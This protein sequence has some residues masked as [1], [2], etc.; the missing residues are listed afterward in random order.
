MTIQLPSS[1]VLKM[2]DIKKNM[3]ITSTAPLSLGNPLFRALAKKKTGTIK[4]SDFYSANELESLIKAG[5]D[6]NGNACGYYR[7][8]WGENDRPQF[9]TQALVGA[10]DAY[11]SNPDKFVFA[12]DGNQPR[13]TFRAL[14]MNNVIY[15]EA[16]AS[17]YQY[18]A[19]SDTT[20]WEW[21]GFPAGLVTG[22]V[23]ELSYLLGPDTVSQPP[24]P[25]GTFPVGQGTNW[26]LSFED[27]FDL[28]SLDNTKWTPH[29]WYNG[30]GQ[31]LNPVGVTNYDISGS[32]LRIWPVQSGGTWIPRDISTHGKFSQVDGYWEMKGRASDNKGIRLNFWMLNHDTDARPMISGFQTVVGHVAG[33]WTASGSND[34]I[35]YA[36]GVTPTTDGQWALYSRYKDLLPVKPAINLTSGD[37]VFGIKK[38]SSRLTFHLDGAEMAGVDLLGPSTMTLPMYIILSVDYV[39]GDAP[40]AD[41]TTVQNASGAFLIDY[42]RA[43]TP[44]TGT[45][46]GE[47]PT[48]LPSGYVAPVGQNSAD[49]PY[50]TF[51][52]EFNQ[53]SAEPDAAKWNKQLWYEANNGKNN[54]RVQDGN[55]YMWPELP[56]ASGTTDHNATLDT[57]GK[58][59]QKYGYF[60]VRAKMPRG[61]GCWPAFWL[62]NHDLTGV[63]PEVD[64]YEMYSGGNTGGNDWGDSSMIPIKYAATVHPEIEGNAALGTRISSQFFGYKNFSDEWH[65]FGFKWI[66]GVTNTELSFYLD[67]SPMGTPIV[68]ANANFDMRMYLILDLWLGGASGQAN[69][70]ETPTGISNSMIVDYVRAWACADGSTVVEGTMP[71]LPESQGGKGGGST[72]PVQK[73]I[74]AFVGNST[75]WGYKS[76]VGGQVSIPYPN[77]FGQRK[78]AYETRNHGVNSTTTAHW[79]AG[80][81]GL[82]Q[83]FAAF[84]AANSNFK[85]VCL[86]FGT[87]DQFDMTTAQFKTNLKAMITE[88]RKVNTRIPILITPFAADF[89]GLAAYAQ[90]VRE[91][92]A[93]VQVAVIDKYTWSLG[94]IQNNGGNVRTFIP[95]GVHPSD[96][97]YIDGGAY[98]ANQWDTAINYVPPPATSTP[99]V[100]NT[101]LFHNDS[102][103]YKEIP[104]GAALHSNNA[105]L[106]SELVAQFS[107]PYPYTH[108]EINTDN[109]AAPVYIVNGNTAPKRTVIVDD[110]SKPPGWVPDPELVSG[111]QNVPFPDHVQ[112]GGG[113]DLEAV[114]YDVAN[115]RM[116]EFWQLRFESGSWRAAWGGVMNNVSRDNGIWHSYFG[117]TATGLPFLGGQITA[118]ELKQGHIDHVIGFSLINPGSGHVWPAQR[119]DGGGSY[120]I[121]E[122]M[123]F[124]L[125]PSY[126]VDASGMHPVAKTIAKAAQKYGFVVW[127]RSGANAVR[128]QGP[129]SYTTLGLPD[130]YYGANALWGEKSPGVLYENYEIL[131]G[132]PWSQCQF[133][134]DNYGQSS[135]PA[136]GAARTDVNTPPPPP[137]PADPMPAVPAGHPHTYTL[138]LNEEFDGSQLNFN[139]WNDHIWWNEGG[140]KTGKPVNWQVSNGALHIWPADGFAPRTIDTDFKY[141]QTQGFFE[142]ES[143]LPIGRGCWPAFWLYNHDGTLR[144][145]VD[146]MEAYSGGAPDTGQFWATPD[147]HPVDYGVTCHRNDGDYIGGWKLQEYLGNQGDLSAGYHKYGALVESDGVT[148]YFDGKQVG[149]KLMTNFFSMRMYILL[150]LY[151]GSASGTPN[152]AETPKGIS[153]A[154]STRYVRAWR[155]N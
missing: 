118:D 123:R 5:F 3:E 153:N 122:G 138:T 63:R 78:T 58:F 112:P 42:V 86:D 33:G 114:I 70:T 29:L 84:M 130:P 96:Q 68:T 139:I 40:D 15:Y 19:G 32:Y 109:Y 18:D 25:V 38:T 37:H 89:S 39:N 148:F 103:W 151:F 90:A 51:R 87:L 36:M 57:D 134:P 22:V 13:N 115:D 34:Q 100:G 142:C 43:W 45:G 71:A 135:S 60:E 146:I 44:S 50:M 26:T 131:N 59:Y 7:S 107:P 69:T 48:P 144:P 92:G 76:G 106:V 28:P 145:E 116:Y 56:F 147:L 129:L 81:N 46:G 47:D 110:D 121:K 41:G 88:V 120:P 24:P 2:S 21:S 152:N 27:N 143:K 11:D 74:V 31:P 4:M 154:F 79:L 104:T 126:N 117:T 91:V 101:K 99:F 102:F 65:V 54:I 61:R 52:E 55:L 98:V 66:R 35:D 132:F 9:G 75:T 119:N 95:D 23:Y 6:D 72:T 127:D 73:P 64:V 93:E 20:I 128:C 82:T 108:C 12:V 1:G 8:F 97:H 140:E 141:Y 155:K 124:R 150:D 17:L 136:D 137:P 62:Y 10:Y 105:A 85:Y 83:T 16:D 94:V 30:P 80:T 149:P 77:A 125:N 67:G 133:M 111:W 53:L 49:F 14:V 113:T